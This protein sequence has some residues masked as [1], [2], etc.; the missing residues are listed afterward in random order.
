MKLTLEQIYRHAVISG[1]N[2][3]PR[4]FRRYAKSLRLVP[5]P[6]PK[7]P[8]LYTVQAANVFFLLLGLLPYVDSTKPRKFK[9]RIVRA[10]SGVLTVAEA[11]GKA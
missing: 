3:S 11:G 8:R 2:V 7:R 9:A 6:F 5:L 4:T 1:F 10:K